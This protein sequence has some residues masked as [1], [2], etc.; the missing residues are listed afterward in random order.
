[1]GYDLVK[2]L[3][4]PDTY[5]DQ[6]CKSLGIWIHVFG[7]LLHILKHVGISSSKHIPLEEQ[8]TIFLHAC[9]TGMTW[10]QHLC[11]RFQRSGDTICNWVLNFMIFTPL[12][13]E[14]DTSSK[15]STFPHPLCFIH[16]VCQLT[17][18]GQDPTW[19]ITKTQGGSP[20]L[21]MSSVLLM[22]H[23]LSVHPL[24]K[25]EKHVE[26]ERVTSCRTASL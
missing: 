12:F 14:T 18:P 21:E 9:V 2:E 26:T 1:M 24:N 22:A 10:T 17:R 5:P 11:E 4:H 19:N 25:T 7:K 23:M 6:I 16:T 3:I 8:L 20:S 15:Y 13:M